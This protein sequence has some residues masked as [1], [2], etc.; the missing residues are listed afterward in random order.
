[1]SKPRDPLP[2]KL[3]VGILLNDK[4][5]L[6]EIYRKLERW[7]GRVDM[8]SGWMDFDFT[9]YY[10]D[11][12]GDTLHRRMLV[13]KELFNQESLAEAKLATND[14]EKEYAVDDKRRVNID[15]GYLLNERF[16]L[17]TGKNYT[18]RIYIGSGI[19]ADL[20]LIYQH[21]DYRSLPWT[22]PDY[23]DE[24]M[25]SFLKQV[26]GKFAADLRQGSSG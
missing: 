19:Y 9:T 14:L 4:S 3:V 10:A 18:H 2:A 17:A 22:Y 11:E 8:V 23:K 26:R 5:L 13:F 6:D 12:M 25:I 16:V 7:F 21:G 24:T 15:P 1:M 20:T